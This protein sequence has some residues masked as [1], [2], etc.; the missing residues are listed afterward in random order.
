MTC[1][2]LYQKVADGNASC[3]LEASEGTGCGDC[4][5]REFSNGNGYEPGNPCRAKL[6]TDEEDLINI[7]ELMD[8]MHGWCKK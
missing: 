1:V 2:E 8:V 4:P 7:L 3:M 5:Y 6:K